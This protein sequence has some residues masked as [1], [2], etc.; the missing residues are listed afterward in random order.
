VKRTICIA[1]FVLLMLIAPARAERVLQ[2][3]DLDSLVFLSTAIVRVEVGDSQP[4]KTADG[5]CVVQSVKVLDVFSGPIKAGASVKVTGLD[6][7]LRATVPT[8]GMPFI[9]GMLFIFS[10]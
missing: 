6:R 8:R 9:T 1:G 10:W 7:F 3:Y 2:H 5:D 4:F